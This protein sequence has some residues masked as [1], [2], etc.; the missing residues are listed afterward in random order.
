[1]KYDVQT[2][3]LAREFMNDD[4]GSYSKLATYLELFR[5]RIDG[6]WTKHSA[7]HLCR[8]N[9]ICSS[10]R[11]KNQPDAGLTQRLRTRNQIIAS[12]LDALAIAGKGISDIAP[13][14]LK[15]ITR[16]SGASLITVRNNWDEL[17]VELNTLA[18]V[19]P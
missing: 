5:P 6:P 12:T 19:W 7:Y 3:E 4:K 17:E 9:G 8:T 16:L 11:C 10:R 15:E 13:V 18:G 2:I 1:M 14:Q